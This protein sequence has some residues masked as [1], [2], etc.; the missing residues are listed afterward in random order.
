MCVNGNF[1][2]H[3]IFNGL[4]FFFDADHACA[5]NDRFSVYFILLTFINVDVNFK[6]DKQPCVSTHS[7]DSEV[8]VFYIA[9]KMSEYIRQ[10]L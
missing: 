1:D 6:V 9:T 7:T 2:D 10:I 5:V 4:E 3:I 8:C